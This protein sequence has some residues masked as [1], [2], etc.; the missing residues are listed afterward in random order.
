MRFY[1]YA[2]ERTDGQWELHSSLTAGPTTY[3]NRDAAL[4]AAKLGCRRRWE[5]HGTP[6]GVRVRAED[7]SWTDEHVEGE[8]GERQK[9]ER[10][11]LDGAGGKKLGD[12]RSRKP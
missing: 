10:S 9:L 6:C 4:L 2:S 1:F 12:R 11:F 5:V 8:P 3:P 7:G